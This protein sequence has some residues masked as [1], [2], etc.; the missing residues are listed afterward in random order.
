MRE[1][2]FRGLETH[3]G[4]E[5]IVGRLL[6]DDVIV[7]SG[8]PFEL[9]DYCLLSGELEAYEVAP[10]TVGQFTDTTDK[11]GVKIFEG[12]LVKY[13]NSVY[14][15]RYSVIQARFLAFLPNGAFDPVAMKYGEVIGNIYDN[16][17]LFGGGDD[18]QEM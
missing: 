18:A 11:N 16:P 14:E 17:E 13:H 2:L 7:P 4:N 15:V 3:F 1:I 8:Q 10:K 12:D 5:W 9:D 6:A